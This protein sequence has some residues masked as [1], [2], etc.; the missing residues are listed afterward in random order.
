MC[1]S[2]LA[3][4]TI[5]LLDGVASL[6]VWNLEIVS[7]ICIQY[8]QNYVMSNIAS[9]S[10]TDLIITTLRPFTD[11]TIT[12]LFYGHRNLYTGFILL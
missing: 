10:Y 9:Q 1:L 3:K 8:G 7:C 11:F 4:C 6:K 12:T 2:N 5:G